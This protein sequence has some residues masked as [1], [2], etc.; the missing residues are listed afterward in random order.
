[1]Q[2][3]PQFGNIN[4]ETM[5]NMSIAK[6]ALVAACSVAVAAHASRDSDHAALCKNAVMT[7]TREFQDIPMAAFS[8]SGHHHHNLLWTIH[9]DGNT[10]NGSCKFHDGH[11]KGV[12][13]HTHLKHARHQKKSDHYKGQY[14]GFYYDRHIG[15]WRDPDGHVC[16]TCTTENGFPK[17]GY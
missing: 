1:V 15:Q 14:G 10:A 12:E 6:L 8:Q 17:N 4:E 13:I 7:Q 16:H 9:W 3:S 11:F 2:S 5:K